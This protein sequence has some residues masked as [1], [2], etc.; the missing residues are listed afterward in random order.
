MVGMASKAV[1]TLQTHMK[2]EGHT[3]SQ[4]AGLNSKHD[5]I[6]FQ[7]WLSVSVRPKKILVRAS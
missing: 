5:V 2:L 4:A 3:P 6:Y 7:V 1:A